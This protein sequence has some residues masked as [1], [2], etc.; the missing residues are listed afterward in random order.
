[1]AKLTVSR[2]AK[3]IDKS[4]GTVRLMLD[5]GILKAERTESGIRLIEP[6]EVDRYKA[7]QVSEPST[8]EAAWP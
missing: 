2:V 6:T 8:T 3:L 5:R 7:T 4:E 1:M